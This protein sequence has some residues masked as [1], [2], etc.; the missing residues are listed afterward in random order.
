MG[1]RSNLSVGGQAVIEGVMMK[2]QNKVSMSV[3]LPDGSID[4]ECWEVKSSN[5]LCF[6]IIILRGFFNFISMMVL[7]Y[8]CLMKSA[9]KSEMFEDK[10]DK[11]DIK[12]N[13][14]Q[15]KLEKILGD[16][17]FNILMAFS[18]I[19]SF[20][21]SIGLFM[22]FPSF[23]VK[24]LGGYINISDGFKSLIEGLVKIFIFVIY[25]SLTS[26]MKE[27]KT[28]YM[29]HGAEHKSIACLES[30]EELTVENIKKYSRFH[31]RCGT[32]FILIS[33]VISILVFSIVSWESLLIRVLLK[34]ILTPVIIGISY[35]IIKF[36]AKHDNKFTR[37]FILPGLL[38]QK[39]T[40]REPND[41]Q[42]EVAIDALKNIN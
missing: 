1:R 38:L 3:R 28:V 24:L 27:M 41:K 26:F 20:V 42:I 15:N 17:L 16:N 22:W 18:T 39:I 37:I 10:E 29:Y 2:N 4:N 19:L 32:S 5:K 40:T 30:G 7:G 35:E 8:K 11:E 12:K 21:F 34:L 14:N 33:L 31:P 23:L 25:I 6:K 36:T 9:E 13:K